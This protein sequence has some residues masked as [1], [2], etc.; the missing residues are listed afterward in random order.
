MNKPALK[1]TA[2]RLSGTPTRPRAGK[3]FAVNLAV[4]RSDTKRPISSGTVGRRV[5]ADG[6]RVAAEGSV[7]DGAGHCSFRVPSTAAGKVL[8]GTITVRTGGKSVAAGF[9]YVVR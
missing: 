8:R 3:P 2:T 1:L 5:L 9:S 6:Q 4:T 7:T